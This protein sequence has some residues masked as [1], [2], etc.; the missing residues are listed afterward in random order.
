VRPPH[1]I[2]D[3]ILDGRDL[4]PA[5]EGIWS[6]LSAGAPVQRYDRRAAGYDRLVGSAL[7]NRLLWGS[8]PRTYAAFADRAARAGRGPLLDAGCGSLVF[9]V[10]TYARPDRPVVLM[11]E[12]I[13]MLRA[14]GDR[15]RRAAGRVPDEVA[16][17][18]GNVRDLPFR[19]ACFST[20]LCMGM[21][22]LFDDIATLASALV[23]ATEP[24]GQ[25]FLT[26]LVA[27]TWIGRRYLSLL[28]RAGEVAAPRTS[29][30]LLKELQPVTASLAGPVSL[31]TEGSIAFIVATAGRRKSLP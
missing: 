20:V 5:G 16:L 6:A 18:Q 28:H 14:G 23:N 19:R 30:R 1:F 29:A 11:D 2:S 7:Y 22:H 9:T 17:V 10:H 31:E 26:S 15:L 13:G 25:L 4:R 8:S 24:G 12:S 27:E 21:L 3:L